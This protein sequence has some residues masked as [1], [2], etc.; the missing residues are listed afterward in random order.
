MRQN[1]ETNAAHI[2]NLDSLLSLGI[3]YSHFQFSITI[4]MM[5][6]M[7]KSLSTY[8]TI[9]LIGLFLCSKLNYCHQRFFGSKKTASTFCVN[10]QT[11]LNPYFSTLAS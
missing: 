7:L 1:M 3:D 6:L 4:P 5:D 2:P 9:P 8:S 11:L 10:S